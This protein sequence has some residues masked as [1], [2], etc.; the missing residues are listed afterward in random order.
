MPGSRQPP[1]LDELHD[2]VFV[3]NN[4][5]VR[6]FLRGEGEREGVYFRL[7][8][9]RR[10]GWLARIRMAGFNVRTLEDRIASLPGIAPDVI[11]GE[12]GVRL[13]ATARERVAAWDPDR[14]RW[15]DLPVEP[16]DGGTGVRVRVD[17]P[18]RRRKSRGGGDFFIAV[19]ERPGRIGLR[20]VAEKEAILHAYSLQASSDRPAL[21]RFTET[22]DGYHVPADRLLLPAP[23]R[24][25][26]EHLSTD[27]TLKWTFAP[28]QASLAEQVFEK[29]GIELQPAQS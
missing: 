27:G 29:L 4:E 21:V 23:H 16:V 12:E 13:L 2:G 17:E 26:L 28:E 20:P 8:T 5:K 24:E 11:P 15:R 3:V 19:L 18:L 6:P 1:D 10:E 25:A 14:L 9:R 22:H 7:Q